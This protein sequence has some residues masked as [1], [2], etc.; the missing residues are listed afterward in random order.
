MIAFI[1][2]ENLAVS[3]FLQTTTYSY[4][5]LLLLHSFIL[6]AIAT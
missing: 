6:N 1:A 5:K 2:H 3:T 4:F